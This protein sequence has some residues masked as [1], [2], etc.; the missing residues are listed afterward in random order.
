MLTAS[1]HVGTVYEPRGRRCQDATSAQQTRN[2]SQPSPVAEAPETQES[3]SASQSLTYKPDVLRIVLHFQFQFFIVQFLSGCLPVV[4][5][6]RSLHQQLHKSHQRHVNGA[7]DRKCL[8]LLLI[9]KRH[10]TSRCQRSSIRFLQLYLDV[11]CCFLFRSQRL[12]TS[13]KK[14]SYSE[15]QA[16]GNLTHKQDRENLLI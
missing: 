11:T 3:H 1:L 10:H 14:L 7:A 4:N 8:T 6:I 9:L 12:K 16:D 5:L 2:L 13:V 15:R